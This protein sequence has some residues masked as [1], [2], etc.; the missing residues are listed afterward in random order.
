MTAQDRLQ[1][2]LAEAAILEPETPPV[3]V[4]TASKLV[5]RSAAG[6]VKLTWRKNGALAS[7][8]GFSS[9]PYGGTKIEAAAAFVAEHRDW[10]GG[11][12]PQN[13]QPLQ[14]R[15]VGSRT[16]VRFEQHLNGVP[17]R[18]AQLILHLNEGNSVEAL[19]S[20]LE[21]NVVTR[22]EWRIQKNEAVELAL[23]A[24][25]SKPSDVPA[26]ERLYMLREGVASPVW[27][28]M[29]RSANPPGDWEYLLSAVTGSVVA[30]QDLRVGNEARGFAFPSN[31][32]R[33]GRE[34]V[35]L[36]NL[37]SDHYLVSE[38]SQVFTHFPALKGQVPPGRVVQGATR[39]DGNFFYDADDARA[40]E[41]QLYFGMESASARFRALGFSGF[42]EPLPGVVFYQDWDADN[43][44]FV[45]AN[46]AFF[47]PVAFGDNRGG[48]F[49]YLTSRNQDTALDTDVI[50]HEYAHAVVND[51][52][53]PRQS[54][55][56][57]ALN[58][59]SADYFS[60]SFLNDPVMA[61][62]AAQIFSL[63]TP[64]LRR[65][66]NRH[67]WPY[68]TVGES[69]ADGNIWSGA[70]WD[71]R[72]RLGPRMADE[73]AINAVAMLYPDSEFYDAAEAAIIAAEELFGWGAAESVAAVME[74]RGILTRA[75]RMASEARWIGSGG[76]A[77][78]SIP[79]AEPG[80][81]LVGGQ[82][83]R[84]DVPHRA[85]KLTVR[86]QATS[87]VR[88][89]IRYRVPVTVEGG[90][91]QGE[92]MSSTS[93]NPSG[94]LSLENIPELQAGTY[95]IAV[96]NTMTN[97]V[98]YSVQVEIE[99]GDPGA[100]PAIIILEDGS[101]GSGSVPSGP[102][103]ASRQ[104]AIE[105]PSGVTAVAL[106]LDGDEDVDLYVRVGGPV[107]ITGTGYPQADLV[108]DSASSH[109]FMRIIGA[110]GGPPPAGT[111]FIGVY[112]YGS[113]TTRFQLQTTLER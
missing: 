14:T 7:A 111:Y 16:Y 30:K 79:A 17:I 48:M 2:A 32:I 105:V 42:D 47:S 82:H 97:A 69:H 62:Y 95:Y 49:F 73:I 59:G 106:T 84:V 99:G 1:P 29:F 31:P 27:R 28:V 60:N 113:A 77:E 20:H 53:G 85:T 44:P 64:F 35:T 38:Q 86:V 91:I 33:G 103:L 37:V 10:L 81:L 21:P 78:G 55:A 15:R 92:Q 83:Y 100:P 9:R 24:H 39:Q 43:G 46:N 45:G 88:F 26:A 3:G 80:Y 6:R 22:G 40:S 34:Q 66:D 94:Y 52:V 11:V 13:L 8:R 4:R 58:E 75:A 102:F 63:R 50:Y 93:T 25:G 61:E 71:V 76:L 72:Q 57:K 112:N 67:S 87:D 107:Y 70:L 36:P 12:S 96:V 90:R 51:L 68:N 104:F 56:F 109:E 54:A 18:G 19:N 89:Y 23:K 41:V 74:Q 110:N 98:D 65:S 5:R 101:T 108:S